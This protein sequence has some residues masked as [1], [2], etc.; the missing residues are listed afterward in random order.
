MIQ[1]SWVKTFKQKKGFTLPVP[2]AQRYKVANIIQK[3]RLIFLS[4]S[5][6][7]TVKGGSNTF[8]KY[9]YKYKICVLYKAQKGFCK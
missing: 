7:G 8:Y 2:K 4:L 6:S 3:L 9:E 1:F 5:I